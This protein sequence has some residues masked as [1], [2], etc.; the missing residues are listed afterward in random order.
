VIPYFCSARGADEK[1][2]DYETVIRSLVYKL[3]WMPGLFVAQ[4]SIAFYNRW[5]GPGKEKPSI[6]RWEELLDCLLSESPK[7]AILVDG[8]DAFIKIEE[9]E[10]FMRRMKAIVDKHP[11]VY[12]LCSSHRSVHV[13]RHLRHT[14][15]EHKLQPEDT[16]A[17]I[18]SFIREEIA[19]AKPSQKEDSIFCKRNR[20]LHIP[21]FVQIIDGD[22]VQ[23][24]CEDLL[25]TLRNTLHDHARGM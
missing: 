13:E 19:F 20:R 6:K 1:R 25:D 16:E 4:T 22:T 3:S 23:N 18:R 21:F 12:F 15:Y 14:L 9:G 11:Q 2:P 8:L 17:D 5:T 7:L 24:G 10:L